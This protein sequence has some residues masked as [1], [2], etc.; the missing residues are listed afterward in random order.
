MT[1]PLAAVVLAAGAGRRMGGPKAELVVDGARL[2]DRAA[3]TARAA[4]CDPVIVVLGAGV[5]PH[6]LPT[7]EAASAVVVNP[8]W[9]VGMSTSLLAGIEAA[10]RAG[11]RGVVV[12]LVDQPDVTTTA[13]R[14]L[15]HAHRAGA[16]LVRATYAGR[17]GHPVVIGAA[18]LA[19]LAADLAANPGDEGARGYLRARAAE[20]ELVPCDDTGSDRDLD[21]PE[22][23]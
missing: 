9:A 11:A 21:A 17:A 2:V 13:I 23:L 18:H 8:D 10:R 16:S 15:A 20:V 19:S 5:D 22:D 3:A 7:V 6:A 4:G 12:L 1:A 14:R